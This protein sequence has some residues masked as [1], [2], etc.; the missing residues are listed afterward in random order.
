MPRQSRASLEVIPIERHLRRIE[1]PAHLSEA[2]KTL[3]KSITAQC[4]PQHF[5]QSDAEL[6]A[7]YCQ[8]CILTSLAFAAAMESPDQLSTW[9]RSARTMAS[10][11]TKLRLCPNARVNP[12]TLTRSHLGLSLRETGG[13]SLEGLEAVRDGARGWTCKG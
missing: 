5:V 6:L 7:A 9:E 1:A 2:E 13:V 10:L 8:A 11:A 4:H 12:L 3:F